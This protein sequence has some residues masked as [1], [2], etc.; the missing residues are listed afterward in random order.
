MTFSLGK[1]Q[2]KVE[3]RLRAWAEAGFLRRLR[4][5]DPTLWAAGPASEVKN[6]L[7]WLDLP[8][9]IEPR[10]AG[11]EA[12]AGEVVAE[13][14][15]HAVLL[16]MGGSSLA[17]EVFERT[18]GHA[19]RHPGLLVLD[20][21]HPEAVA[22][23]ERRLDFGRTLF[24]VSSKSGTTVEPLSF[25]RYFWSR[26]GRVAPSPGRRFIAITDPGTPLAALARKRGFRRVFEAAP[27][28]GGRF[29]ALTEFGLVPAVLIGV[30]VR[31]LL[32]SAREEARADAAG[33]PER[34][35][36][37]LRLG[38][39]LGEVAAARN[40]L[41]FL[42]SPSLRSFPDWIEQLVA[43][44]TGK[45]GKGIIPVVGE[46]ALPAG[47]YGADR[48][49]VSFVVGSDPHRDVDQLAASLELAGHPVVRIQIED[50]YSLGAEIYRW[51]TAVAAAGAVLSVNP[52]DQP[53]VE[54][55]KELARQAMARESGGGTKAAAAETTVAADDAPALSAALD[56]WLARTR[57]GDYL[58]LQAYLAPGEAV[59]K[60]LRSLR[61]ALLARTGLPTTMGYGPR[62]L[63]STGQLHK[64]GPN[65]ACLLQLVDQPAADLDIPETDLTFGNLIRAQALGDYQA[66]LQRGRRILRVD[67]GRDAAAGLTRLA[68]LAAS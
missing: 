38:A 39:V 15:T 14:F 40:K 53:D 1:D 8:E 24:L 7:G 34:L 51:E 18:F 61:Q 65:E 19:P 57:S 47:R 64:G 35:S 59:D 43:E 67:V 26:S 33:A 55:A 44:S 4:A 20:S 10:L 9:T 56:G 3:A 60:A 32:A 22:A 30:D 23:V 25:F 62:F 28:V 21:T 52:F 31:K 46:P 48:L 17:P 58:A 6:R 5:K 36:S 63:H 11:I 13:G 2:D 49:F 37:A 29:S 68:A 27:D 50:R 41:T 45:A 42:V 12:F 16:G 54:L 66:L